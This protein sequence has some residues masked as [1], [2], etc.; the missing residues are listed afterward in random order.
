MITDLKLLLPFVPFSKDSDGG[1]NSAFYS[2][3]DVKGDIVIDCSYSKFFLEMGT[4]E[5]PRY[6]Q[7]IVSWLGSS[8]KRKFKEYCKDGT[9]YRPKSIDL[10]IDWDDK[11]TG[12]KQRT[13]HM[14][15][16]Q[17]MK[18]LFAVDW[19]GSIYD[20]VKG[21]HFSTLNSLVSKYYNSSRGDKFYVW[22]SDYKIRNQ[23]EM[24]SFLS[25]A[26]LGGGTDSYLIAEIGRETKSDNFEYL[27]IVTDGGVGSGDIDESDKR[28]EKYGL[29]YSFV[30]T[31]IIGRRGEESVGCPYSRGCPGVIYLI[32]MKGNERQQAS[33]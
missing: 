5:T 15:D 29:Q 25:R 2:S 18:T 9:E 23:S 21:I 26:K 33:L 13:K 22:G 30:S 31:Y 6:I 7:N 10:K 4:K 1:F 16:P 14:T 19:S 28:V 20:W 11:W 3:N 27:V 17:N 24:E 8:E 12:F 32:D